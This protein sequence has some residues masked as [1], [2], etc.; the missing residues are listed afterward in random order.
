[1]K[2]DLD[3]SYQKVGYKLTVCNERF[4][5]LIWNETVKNSSFLLCVHENGVRQH[6]CCY[7]TKTLGLLFMATLLYFKDSVAFTN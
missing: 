4:A 5:G 6:S 1:M 3:S 2:L 7:G